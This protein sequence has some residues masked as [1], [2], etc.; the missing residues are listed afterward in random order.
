VTAEASSTAAPGAGA[1]APLV[2]RR[3]LGRRLRDRLP[4]IALI[5]PGVG[6][7]AIFFLVPL[8]IV[9]VVSL[10]S[11]DARNHLDFSRLGSGNYLEALRP[12]YLPAIAN[13]LR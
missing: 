6:W 5:V 2:A 8:V 1:A 12:E 9:F 3:P 11:N 4:T 7:L 13:T 10:A